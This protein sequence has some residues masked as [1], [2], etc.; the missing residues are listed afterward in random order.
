[1]PS[2]MAQGKCPLAYK[3]FTGGMKKQFVHVLPFVA[4]CEAHDVLNVLGS[5]GLG[6]LFIS[7]PTFHPETS[8]VA[9]GPTHS[10]SSP[11]VLLLLLLFVFRQGVTM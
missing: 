4:P 5:V 7:Q 8:R 3:C 10:S 9:L 11:P 2:V 1:M 6:M